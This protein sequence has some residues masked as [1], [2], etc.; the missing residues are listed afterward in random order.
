MT[1]PKSAA[2]ARNRKTPA[3][4]TDDA[5]PVDPAVV[6]APVDAAEML[7]LKGLLDRVTAVVG[8]KKKGVKEIVEATLTQLGLALDAGEQINLPGFGKLRVARAA[9]GPDG[10]AMTLKLRRDRADGPRGKAA[11]EA[12]AAANDQG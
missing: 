7:R 3:A 12:L 10:G 8:G 6:A 1:P 2:P 5:L 11:K 9:Q 4:S